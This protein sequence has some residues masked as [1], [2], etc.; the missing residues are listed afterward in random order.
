MKE[1]LVCFDQT[2]IDWMSILENILEIQFDRPSS[3][4]DLHSE[5]FFYQPPQ[6]PQ[7][8]CI[9]EIIEKEPSP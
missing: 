3:F 1:Q 7:D 2:K 5:E 8:V 9:K 4:R 6:Y